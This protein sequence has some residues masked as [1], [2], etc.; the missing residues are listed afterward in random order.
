VAERSVSV[1]L[2][3]NI[4]QYEAAMAR[5]ASAGG[6]FSAE[7]Q[8]SMR[9]LGGD[10]QSVGGTLTRGVTLPLA[11]AGAGA[12]KLG[13]DFGQAFTKMQ[14]LAGVTAG[15]VDGLQASV[16]KLAGETARSPQDLA[17]ALYF[18]RSSGLDAG[19]AMDALEMS[20]K[21]SAAGLGS[22]AT[23]A[24]LVSSAMNA[25]ATS[26]LTAADATDTLI[27]TARAGK[28]EP[29]ELA[30]ALGR[31]LPVASEL[32]VTF[33]DV[34]GAIASLSLSGNDAEQS[35]T[36][37]FNVLEKLLK[38]S[39][40]SADALSA[41]GMSVDTIR[42]SIADKGLLVTLQDLKARLGDAGFVKFMEDARAVT[43][44]LA[45]T[46]QNAA[47]VAKTFDTVKNSAG[48][49]SEA[50][51][52]AAGSGMF[53]MQQAWADLQVALIQ[54]GQVI[55]PMV[56]GVI[57][58]IGNLDSKFADLPGPAQA[59]VLGFLA[60]VA[61]AGPLLAIGGRIVTNFG[62][63]VSALEKLKLALAANPWILAATVIAGAGVALYAF[64]NRTTDAEKAMQRAEQAASDLADAIGQTGPMEAMTASLTDIV[65]KNDDL[66]GA[67]AAAGVTIGD[68][69]QASLG[70]AAAFQEITNKITAYGVQSGLTLEQSNA[71]GNYMSI[72]MK[73]ALSSTIQLVGE[74]E[75]AQGN[76]KTVTE[77]WQVALAREKAT[78]DQHATS[79]KVAITVTDE[80]AK[81][82]DRAK[83]A[84]DA[85]K[86]A[87][88][89]ET[90]ALQKY[91]DKL[92]QA[93]GQ[94][95]DHEQ[96][97][98]RLES[99]YSDFEV[100]LFKTTSA[101][102]KGTLKGREKEQ[103][104]RELRST[105]LDLAGQAYATAEA[106][107]AQQQASGNASSKA[108]LMKWRLAQL[109][110]EFPALR[111]EIQTYINKLNAIP[112]QKNTNVITT[113]LTRRTA[114]PPGV[115]AAAGGYFGQQTW[116]TW[117][118]AGPEAILPLT[119]PVR[120]SMLLK[121]QR[122][123]SPVLAAMSSNMRAAPQQFMTAPSAA[124]SPRSNDVRDV[125]VNNYRR[126]IG[127]A[128]V[129]TAIRLAKLTS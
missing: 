53:K 70:G 89:K 58:V 46:G 90:A 87:V 64:M 19:Q 48:L 116:G 18:L 57:T 127:V 55:I 115:M 93:T 107:A 110:N 38:P 68:V 80:D 34:G 20:A 54:A 129:A 94:T 111:G 17:D 73:H 109:A 78:M 105:E 37:L 32:G 113:F 67:M 29:A 112:A 69:A 82:E 100:Q 43:G 65:K 10:M 44:A 91:I 79:T 42:A 24:D 21:A 49:T 51:A 123:L 103:A 74:M 77:G 30:A 119:D 88:D 83:A 15:E 125:V 114:V 121:D 97:T 99:A 63:I 45:L 72:D 31:V 6:R 86:A 120:L 101:V 8:S 128:D 71:L 118:E 36:Q 59:V 5:A 23:V 35:T 98:L 4:S 92:F 85:A 14:T 62:T 117:A 106:F 81:A 9:K 22:T 27:A 126:D 108:D 102:A 16:L 1:K 50:F 104:N 75:V 13:L 3:A 7:T 95:F 25:Y 28:A 52:T 33:Q 11:L 41:V 76:A 122:I 124:T 39:K 47:T 84:H 96:S 60:F 66:R 56:T 12:V 2:L 40:Q 61:A 26:G